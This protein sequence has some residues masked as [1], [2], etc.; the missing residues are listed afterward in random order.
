M[1]VRPYVE[2]LT[3]LGTHLSTLPVDARIG[4]LILFGAMFGV[5]DET[6]TVAAILSHR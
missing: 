3:S 5:A 4:K 1:S 2:E 6:L